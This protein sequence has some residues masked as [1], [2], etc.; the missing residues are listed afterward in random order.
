MP[1]S[2]VFAVIDPA[3]SRARFWLHAL[4]GYSI[5]IQPG[6]PE[7][8]RFTDGAV[9]WTYLADLTRLD[10]VAYSRL[11]HHLAASWD[12][13]FAEVNAELLT[14]GLPI[15]DGPDLIATTDPDTALAAFRLLAANHS[16]GDPRDGR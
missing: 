15:A 14:I 3:S 16:P 6:P 10:P 7:E 5:P 2:P 1:D 13:T 9:R 11:V 12:A 8:T 4:L